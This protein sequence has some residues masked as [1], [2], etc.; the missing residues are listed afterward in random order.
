MRFTVYRNTNRDHPR[1]KH[2]RILVSEGERLSYVGNNFDSVVK[3]YNSLCRY[4]LLAKWG[5][6]VEVEV[7]ELLRYHTVFPE[8]FPKAVSEVPTETVV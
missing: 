3:K 2:Q 6:N 4:G 1:K 5:K 7:E 8:V